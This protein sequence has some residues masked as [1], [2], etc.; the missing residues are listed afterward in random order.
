MKIHEEK[1]TVEPE[2]LYMEEVYAHA[3]NTFSSGDWDGSFAWYERL[4]N[5]YPDNPYKAESLFIRGYI[6]KTLYNERDSAEK[7]FL[8]LIND[9]PESDFCD[10]AKFELQH[11]N[12]PGFMPEF[13]KQENGK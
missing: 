11:L 5:D 10:S 6:K 13:E 3:K 9:H 4:D 2:F 12:D 1:I 8:E 7:Y